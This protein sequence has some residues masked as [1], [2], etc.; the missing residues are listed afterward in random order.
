MDKQFLQQAIELSK[1]SVKQDGFPVGAV[2][3]KNGVVISEGL[4]NGKNNKDA[5]SHAEIEAI[6]KASQKLDSRDIFDCEIYSS[7]EPCLM[8]FSACYWSKIKKI[9]YAVSKD[10][11]SKQHY[12][13]LHSLEEINSKNNKQIEIIHMQELE[14]EA[15]EIVN[16]WEELKYAK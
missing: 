8:C 7:M 6:R 9:V 10:K 4:S 11:L 12:E 1:E 2:I 13:G 3:V 14:K 5:T 15:L 16:N